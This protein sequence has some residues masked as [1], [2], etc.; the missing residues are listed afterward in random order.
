MA[1]NVGFC[2][3]FADVWINA[4]ADSRPGGLFSSIKTEEINYVFIS[5][6]ICQFKKEIIFQ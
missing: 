2:I 6:K 4:E 5:I 1:F 3:S